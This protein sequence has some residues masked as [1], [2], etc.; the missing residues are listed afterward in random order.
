[1]LE[2]PP[3]RAHNPQLSDGLF[4][5]WSAAVT[6]LSL[7][8]TAVLFLVAAS[9]VRSHPGRTDAQGGHF[10]RSTGEYHYHNGGPAR[11][12]SPPATVTTLQPRAATAPRVLATPKPATLARPTPKLPQT[13]WH[14]IDGQVL[15]VGGLLSFNGDAVTVLKADNSTLDVALDKLCVA[16]RAFALTRNKESEFQRAIRQWTSSNGKYHVDAKAISVDD[17]TVKLAQSGKATSIPL[18]KLSTDD[19]SY[20]DRLQQAITRPVERESDDPFSALAD[21]AFSSVEAFTG[22]TT[23]ASADEEFDAGTNRNPHYNPSPH[24][25]TPSA[26]TR[27]APQVGEIPRSSPEQTVHVRGYYRK[28]GTYVR[29]HYRRPPSR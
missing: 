20:L 7:V 4:E 27:P 14:G 21:D 22:S 6:R 23:T 10:N 26:P 24:T 16:D 29:P 15:A 1:V 13:T 17:K 3:V 25:S 2:L 12:A 28:D 19:R 8:V 18:D 5:R 11:P 9:T